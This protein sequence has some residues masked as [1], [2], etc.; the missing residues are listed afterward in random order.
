[1]DFPI[2]FRALAGLDSIAQAAGR[3]NR[4]GILPGKGMVIVFVAPKK[5]PS[6]ILRKAADT[7]CGILSCAQKDPLDHSLFEKYFSELYWKANSL[8]SKK[9]ISLLTP[10]HQECGIFFRTASEKFQIIDDSQQRAILVRY[11]ESSRMIDSLKY[12]WL[13][14]SVMRKLQRYTV[15]VFTQ[16]F[17]QLLC[18]GLIEEI[19]PHIYVLKTESHYSQKTGLLV[20][21][22][23]FDPER[24]IQ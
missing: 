6:G 22:T 20:D 13:N 1:M 7:A 18:Q 4:E 11:G 15:N 9:I 16:E 12:T 3:C 2:V 8:D 5:P 10:D 21:E 17:N 14:R 23:L 19:Q 24:F